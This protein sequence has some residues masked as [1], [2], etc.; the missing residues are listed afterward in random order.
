MAQTN[1]CWGM[2]LAKER[3]SQK[4]NWKKEMKQKLTEITQDLK[5][6]FNTFFILCVCP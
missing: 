5:L 4:G 2:N 1:L 3:K 6:P